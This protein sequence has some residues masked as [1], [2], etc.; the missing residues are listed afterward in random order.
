M[1][2]DKEAKL[3]ALDIA[4]NQIEKDHGKGAVMKMGEGPIAKIDAI[5]TG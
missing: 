5:S 1:T 4:L 2:E 3:K